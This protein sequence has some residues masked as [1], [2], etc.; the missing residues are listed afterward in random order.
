MLAFLRRCR[1]CYSGW[2]LPFPIAVRQFDGT[3]HDSWSVF[4]EEEHRK[5][6]TIQ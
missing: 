3:F 4:L 5:N 6:L 2:N 1:M